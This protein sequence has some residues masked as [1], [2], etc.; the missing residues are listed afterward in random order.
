MVN[1]TFYGNYVV[2]GYGGGIYSAGA[3]LYITNSIFWANTDNFPGRQ[4]Y[5]ESGVVSINYGCFSGTTTNDIYAGGSLT[6][7]GV[8]TNNPLFA[9][10]AGHDF[11]LQSRAGRWTSG[12]WVTDSVNSP[13]IDAGN[14][15]SAFDM[16]PFF[17]G[18]RI[19]LG[20]YGDTAQASKSPA[21]PA[22]NNTGATY[23]PGQ[24]VATLSGTLTVT[25]GAPA[26]VWVYWGPV[27]G[28]NNAAGLWA[29]T[30]Y[31]STN[32]AALPAS[33]A[34]NVPVSLF[35]TYYYTYKSAN[36]YGTNWATPSVPF[37]T[38]G[39]PP[40]LTIQATTPNAAELGPVSGVF[41]VT[42]DTNMNL[43]LPLTV[44]YSIGGTAINGTDYTT[45][46]SSVTIPAGL[47]TATITV[48]PLYDA[49]V[50]GDET[51]V[52][53]LTTNLL[54]L[55]DT[56]SNATVTIADNPSAGVVVRLD[57]SVV[58]GSND[59]SSW[60]NACSNFA[61]AVFRV[62]GG[63]AIWAAKGTYVLASPVTITT[64]N[65]TVY[66]GF[67]N[68]MTLLSQRDAAA[69]AVIV[70]GNLASQCFNITAANATLD[71]LTIQ[72][73]RAAGN[74]A[75]IYNAGSGLTLNGCILSN[76][77]TT[78]DSVSGGGIY[79]TQPMQIL[80]SRVIDNLSAT[81]GNGSGGGAIL[82]ASTGT[83]LVSNTVF[84]G[85]MA[86]D[87]NAGDSTSYGA[88]GA[89]H[90]YDAG[91]LTA[92][93]CVFDGN[94]SLHYEDPS[95][96]KT[97]R[98]GAIYLRSSS[99]GGTVINCTFSGNYVV[100][101][102]GG[103]IYSSGA[104]L[105][106]TN[107]IFWANTCTNVENRGGQVYSS[108]LASIGY[109]CFSGTNA[110]DIYVAGTL[111]L[112]HAITNDP[113]FVSAAGHD[114][115]LQ[116]SAGHWTPGGWV[117]DPGVNSPCIDAGDPASDYSNEPYYNGKRINLGAYGNTAQASR[118]PVKGTTLLFR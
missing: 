41:T 17:N 3:P 46:P 20:A 10:A 52:L 88:G 5:S 39:T 35:T 111:V 33:Y 113:L 4:I 44:Y 73:G 7:T 26:E 86:K 92:L 23:I 106:I 54:Y 75:G 47:T 66:G 50:E 65:V 103:G 51:V 85:N 43:A 82:F 12:G 87:A 37:Y 101:G 98:G 11:H 25:G 81:S 77:V 48:T 32:T 57:P 96:N 71:G 93:N 38:I 58:G 107:C 99:G 14:P 68:G 36:A 72:R 19:N 45:I 115:H 76:C 42:G 21:D 28:T 67:T 61:S 91:Q 79:S 60:A 18:G 84:Q 8:I 24:T 22:V 1:C 69:N 70:D 94:G 112:S 97:R 64:T 30:N 95:Y 116:S 108:G 118:T 56:P 55:V 6:L 53:T 105:Y 16:E 63:G 114:L 102:Y 109:G 83:L 2:W 9:S 78:A 13:C 110:A 15:A 90:M 29:N 117:R 89:I 100:Q 31:F 59:G 49:L 104:P 74:G 34:T 40:K 27:D 80:N 62:A